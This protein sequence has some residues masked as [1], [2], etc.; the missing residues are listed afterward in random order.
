MMEQSRLNIEAL[1]IYAEV[2]DTLDSLI[3]GCHFGEFKTYPDG[4]ARAHCQIPGLGDV[5]FDASWPQINSECG[6]LI[7]V[8]GNLN[9]KRD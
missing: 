5:S 2:V 7:F 1:N 6:G 8:T 4:I 9:G 3:P